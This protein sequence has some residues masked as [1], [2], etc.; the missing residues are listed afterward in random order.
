[1][2]TAPDL[3]SALIMNTGDVVFSTGNL[4]TFGN[5]YLLDTYYYAK[6]DPAFVPAFSVSEDAADLLVMDMLKM[7]F[8]EGAQFCK[9]DT[10]T[11][12][13]LAVG[14]ATLQSFQSHK[15]LRQDLESGMSLK[16]TS[17]SL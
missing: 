8:G 16:L 4:F 2:N 5:K 14:N 1:M 15:A 9:Y 10:L 13:S 6:H 11:T 12:C 3:R 7:C 17:L